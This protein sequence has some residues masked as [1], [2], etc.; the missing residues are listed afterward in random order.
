MPAAANA[1]NASVLVAGG[2]SAGLA[3]AIAA[4]RQGASTILVERLG[5]LGGMGTAA[6][7]HS[8][9]GLYEPADDGGPPRWAN[10][11][12]PREFAER[13]IARGG[14]SAPVRM[15]RMHVLP[16][17][18]PTFARVAD[19]F[20]AETTGLTILLHAEILSADPATG[21]VEMVSRGRRETMRAT[22]WIDA[23]GDA[24]LA[25]L[26]GAATERAPLDRLQ[27]PAFI[28]ALHG[29]AS[30]ALED[31]ARLRLAAKIAHAVR[32]DRLPEGALGTAIRATAPGEAYITI[33]LAHYDPDA[34][35]RLEI[36]GRALATTL[37]AFLRDEVDGF[38][39]ARIGAFP[40][41]A[42]IRESHRVV[43]RA[44]LTAADLER[45]ADFP[46]AAARATWPM[47]LRETHHGPRLRYGRPTG[48]P[49]G[50]LRA[51]DVDR[52]FVAG[53]CIS[54]DHEAQASI[55]VMGTCL[56]TGEAAGRAAALSAA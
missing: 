5:M 27:R 49:L 25:R 32:G 23:T 55:R 10:P 19:E 31:D 21:T 52:L 43:G 18:P 44:T 48:I 16:H 13:L 15:G 56:A 3:A 54:C 9:C 26:A 51:R 14:A 45:G 42:G 28:F 11:G 20:V 37:T 22:A 30:G 36:E 39:Q 24:E 29:V 33:D 34:P 12:F 53:R 47:E 38:A 4:A 1:V 41:R 50:C 40:V 7:V 6:L 35:G 2:G 46:D 17:H 8:I